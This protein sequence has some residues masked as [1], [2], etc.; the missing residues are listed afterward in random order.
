VLLL[1]FLSCPVFPCRER[2]TNLVVWRR[3]CGRGSRLVMLVMRSRRC[4]LGASTMTAELA[5]N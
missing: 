3:R 2:E 5:L 4:D 1:S